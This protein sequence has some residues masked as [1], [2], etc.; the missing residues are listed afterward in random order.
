MPLTC[1]GRVR[2]RQKSRGDIDDALGHFMLTLVDTLDTLVVLNET[3]EF[4]RAAQLVADGLSFDTNVV[5]SVFET[6]I[7][8]L[9]GLLGAHAMA[10][11]L[12][13]QHATHARRAADADGRAPLC[14]FLATYR[15]QL[16]AHAR[17]IGD[18]LYARREAAGGTRG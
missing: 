14:P 11:D 5:V 2:G 6:N 16:L 4:C 17:D 18:R 15:N 1:Q 9:G 10:V 13:R 12:R 8:V 3:A 7:R